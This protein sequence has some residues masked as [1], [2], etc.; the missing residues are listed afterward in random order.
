MKSTNR[1][2]RT[3]WPHFTD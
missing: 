1:E 2:I 3:T